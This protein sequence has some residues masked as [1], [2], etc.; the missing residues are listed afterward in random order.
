MSSMQDLSH[1]R[2]GSPIQSS[3]SMRSPS[4]SATGKS[5]T[6]AVLDMERER[7]KSFWASTK[8]DL[9]VHASRLHQKRES[10]Q[11][12]I[13][14]L[15]NLVE[16]LQS[17]NAQYSAKMAQLETEVSDGRDQIRLAET[18]LKTARV[19]NGVLRERVGSL[20][21]ELDIQRE[22]MRL[23]VV[24]YDAQARSCSELVNKVKDLSNVSADKLSS[25]LDQNAM[26]ESENEALRD[27]LVVLKNTNQQLE[28][29][30][31]RVRTMERAM[32]SCEVHMANCVSAKEQVGELRETVRRLLGLLGRTQEFGGLLWNGKTD[33]VYFRTRSRSKSAVGASSERSTSHQSGFSRRDWLPADALDALRMF[34]DKHMPHVSVDA[35]TDLLG[36]VNQAFLERESIALSKLKHKFKQE[37]VDL[38]RQVAQRQP[39]SSV[40]YEERIAHLK[41]EVEDAKSRGDI[42][43]DQ[44]EWLSK[45]G[46]LVE[47]ISGLEQENEE[48]RGRVGET[49]STLAAESWSYVCVVLES[50]LKDLANQPVDVVRD[51]LTRLVSFVRLKASEDSRSARPP[52]SDPDSEGDSSDSGSESEL[53]ENS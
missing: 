16:S 29:Y 21:S 34:R 31:E 53:F 23:L 19:E 3:S 49:S 2:L 40:V 39:Y 51:H 33:L 41:R 45:F 12:E 5:K 13:H 42:R 37:I 36:A 22:E 44:K 26:L 20:Q 27:T 52:V 28:S 48:L 30:R 46:K 35:F 17:T 4:L 6:A 32:R 10:E 18:A 8:R 9:A 7:L 50:L 24:R 15:K 25:A 43:G 14:V 11:A 1:A 38:K 47:R